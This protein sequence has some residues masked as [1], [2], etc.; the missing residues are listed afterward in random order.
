MKKT[1]LII[2]AVAVSFSVMAQRTWVVGNDPVNFPVSAGIGA[3]P[4]VSVFVNDLGIHTGTVTNVNMG[5]VE[6]SAKTFGDAS[7]VNRFKFNGAG[8]GSASDAQTEPTT[9]MPTQRFITV[10]VSGPGTIKIQGITG[11]S[12]ST[13]RLFVTN[14]SELLGTMVFPAGSEINEETVEYSGG[15]AVLYIY[16]NAAINLY[17]I[18]VSSATNHTSLPVTNVNSVN[19]ENLISFNGKEIVNNHNLTLEVYNVVG[20]LV[21]SSSSTINTESFAK[22]IYM[23]R[24]EGQKAV[25][26][27]SK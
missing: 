12:S 3:G 15:E 22:G 27:F 14:G 16:G 6:A 10:K 21:A 11:S 13:R 26:K 5:Q 17:N 23:V 9:M 1:L 25:L 2:A 4:D 7:Y 8:Y 24:A 20:R 19:A 18:V